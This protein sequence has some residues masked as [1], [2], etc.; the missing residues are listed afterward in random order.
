MK[1]YTHINLKQNELQNAV[2][3]ALSSAPSGKMG[4]LY[5]NTNDKALYQH[6]GTQ[7][8]RVAVLY[9]LTLGNVSNN[10]VPINLVGADGTTDTI[11]IK[12][13][14]GSTI[15]K[16]GSTI[17]INSITYSQGTQQQLE[18]G[19]DTTGKLWDAS[20]IH[21]YIASAIGG[22]EAM[23]FK[24]T[25]S[26]PT[27]VPSTNVSAGDTYMIDVAGTY[28][29]Q[30]CEVGDLLIA[31]SSTPTWTVMQTNING[32]ITN[33]IAGTGVTI[34]GSGSSR[35]ISADPKK[36]WVG[37][38]AG[39][40]PPYTITTLT[41]DFS[42]T[43][44]DMVMILFPSDA[45]F[46]DGIMLTIDNTTATPMQ[47]WGASVLELYAPEMVCY[48][49]YSNTYYPVGLV[50]RFTVDDQLDEYST[51]PVQN[52]VI[53]TAINDLQY[54]IAGLNGAIGEKGVNCLQGTI[55]AGSTEWTYPLPQNAHII[56]VTGVGN[57]TNDVYALDWRAYYVGGTYTF[58][59]SIA[60]PITESIGVSV[61][62]HSLPK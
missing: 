19:T 33:L 60:E 47:G 51:N 36:I 9:D 29:G 6:N 3:H 27:D 25:L 18:A 55:Y 32:A 4:Q 20:T 38:T 59:A 54:D 62:Y 41:G 13:T 22:I 61:H 21:N 34:T 49:Y 35:T 56:A 14:G 17:T 31:T 12:A 37:Y 23:R 57:T 2:I 39:T 5:Y 15:T 30:V 8:V 44:G 16:N 43:D 58:E 46:T 45:V 7:W 40:V 1:Y 42:R 26:D 10:A 50:Q 11:N 28:A 24:G 52:T 53:T 48:V